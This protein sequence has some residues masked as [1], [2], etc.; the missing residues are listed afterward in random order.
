LA[1]DAEVNRKFVVCQQQTSKQDNR[2][3]GQQAGSSLA[4][5][6]ADGLRCS[7]SRRQP[8]ARPGMFRAALLSEVGP[9]AS[10]SLAWS[11]DHASGRRR[12]AGGSRKVTGQRRAGRRRTL[13]RLSEVWSYMLSTS[14]RGTKGSNHDCEPKPCH[15]SAPKCASK[16]NP[17]AKGGLCPEL[18][19]RRRQRGAAFRLIT[20]PRGR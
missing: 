11:N 5:G 12:G 7:P 3:A 20:G 15:C 14:L 9:C 19:D 8:R 2:V 6:P 17:G 13:L 10:Q 16:L 1:R 4:V 18:T